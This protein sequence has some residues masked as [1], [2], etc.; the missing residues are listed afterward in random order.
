VN[1]R[2]KWINYTKY[3]KRDKLLPSLIILKPEL[4]VVGYNFSQKSSGTLK[5]EIW[6]PFTMTWWVEDKL[7]NIMF[8]V[9]R[10]NVVKINDSA[11]MGNLITPC[12][13]PETRNTRHYL[14]EVLVTF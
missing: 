9:S 2:N 7:M 5:W 1:C 8:I 4:C 12:K 13:P 11:T 14:M 10:L 6:F 3:I